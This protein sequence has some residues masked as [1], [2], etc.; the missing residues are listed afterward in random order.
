M[1]IKIDPET[2][3]TEVVHPTFN[4]NGNPLRVFLDQS[5]ITLLEGDKLDDEKLKELDLLIALEDQIWEITARPP[6]GIPGTAASVIYC[7]SGQLLIK[8]GICTLF[9]GKM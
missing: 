1:Q 3:A 2:K 5:I 7:K 6:V 4:R 8:N 9:Y